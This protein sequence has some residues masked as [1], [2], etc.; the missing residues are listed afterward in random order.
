MSTRFLAKNDTERRILINSIGPFWD[1]NEVWL[2]TAGGAM[3]AAFPNWYATLF[4]GFYIPLVFLLLALIGRGVAFEFRGKVD[5]TRWKKYGMRQF[6]R[7]RA[8]SV[9]A[10]RCVRLSYSG[11][12]D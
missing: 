12:S 6:S 2:L 9:S 3:F 4:S 5:N 1:A 8:A 10:W 7:Q 11:A